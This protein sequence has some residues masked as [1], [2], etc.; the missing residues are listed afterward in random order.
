[1]TYHIQSTTDLFDGA[2]SRR[3][4]NSLNGVIPAAGRRGAFRQLLAELE[5]LPESVRADVGCSEDQLIKLRTRSS[6]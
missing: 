1:M 3:S 2:G 4:R 5:V 6:R